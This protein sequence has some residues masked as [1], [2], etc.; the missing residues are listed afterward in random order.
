LNLHKLLLYNPKLSDITL[1]KLNRFVK[2]G[3]E[4]WTKSCCN[5]FGRNNVRGERPIKLR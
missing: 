3:V 5:I 2:G 1:F 4:D